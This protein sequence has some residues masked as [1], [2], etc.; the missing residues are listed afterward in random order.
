MAKTGYDAFAIVW[1]VAVVAYLGILT[2]GLFCARERPFLAMRGARFMMAMCCA[3]IVHVV[4]AT[5]AHQHAEELEAVERLSCVVWGYWLPYLAV[6]V[7]FSAQFLQVLSYT[8]MLAQSVSRVRTRRAIFARPFVAVVTMTP[9]VI[10]AVV[11]SASPDASRVDAETGA[12]T[13]KIGAKVAIAVWVAVC[14]LALAMSLAW[15]RIVLV[16]DAAREM[17]R[18]WIVLAVAVAVA[19]AHVLVVVVAAGGFA[20]VVNRVVATLTI[21]ALYAV[22]M[23]VLAARPLWKVLRR[24]A[25]YEFVEAEKLRSVHQPLDS[26][27]TLLD[28]T[29]DAPA[30]EVEL[31]IAD[32]LLFCAEPGRE[33]MVRRDKT[34]THPVRL[35]SLYTAADAWTRRRRASTAHKRHPSY[36]APLYG[37]KATGGFPPLI[38]EDITRTAANVVSGFFDPPHGESTSAAETAGELLMPRK[39]AQTVATA[40]DLARPRGE[41]PSDTFREVLWWVLETLDTYFGEMYMTDHIRRRAV[42]LNDEDVRNVIKAAANAESLAR[43]Q[44]GGVVFDRV[45][46]HFDTDSGREMHNGVWD[47]S[48]SL[49]TSS[50]DSDSISDDD[51]DDV[52]PLHTSEQEE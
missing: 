46:P 34:E 38:S 39:M 23:S 32:F 5:V 26:V 28:H 43:L 20:D 17:P 1:S 44:T 9:P 29:A 19:V 50:S 25:D 48:V 51:D 13:S 16:R 37:R 14:V 7:W 4:A 52:D 8:A 45:P 30:P 35:V 27:L 33:R 41:E 36:L 49:N 22:A 10:I 2:V 40:V 15:S 3:A 24:D 47:L 21:G 42:W 6:G 12:C 11:V 31:V 18:Q